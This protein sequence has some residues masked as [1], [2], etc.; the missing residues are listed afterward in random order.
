MGPSKTPT[1]QERE[2]M[3]RIA[4]HACVACLQD[5]HET[6]ASV[7]HIIQGNR[8]MGHLFTIPLCPAHHTGTEV[9]SVHNAKRTFVARYGSELELLAAL[10]VR[11]GVYDK[12][13][14]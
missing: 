12:V 5:G 9:P 6:P 7:H 10:Q 11:L 13:A 1:K 8:R 3:A 2:W 14:A 4:D